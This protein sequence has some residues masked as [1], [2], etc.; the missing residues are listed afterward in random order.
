MDFFLSTPEDHV[1]VCVYVHMYIHMYTYISAVSILSGKNTGGHLLC[2]LGL[3][4][5]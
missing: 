2:F 1:H 4:W 5:G 3:A